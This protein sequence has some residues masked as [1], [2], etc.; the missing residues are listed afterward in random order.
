MWQPQGAMTV[1]A[2]ITRY[3]LA[4]LRCLVFVALAAFGFVLFPIWIAAAISIVA[5]HPIARLFRAVLR[6]QRT[7]I[8]RWTGV[9]IEIGEREPL[10]PE[11]R[12][13]RLNS[14]HV[15][16]SYAVFCLKKKK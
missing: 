15:K 14:S 16:I 6:L 2:M 9:T 10:E 1:N 5:Y 12:S 13:T 3:L 4:P 11:R 7:L 8:H